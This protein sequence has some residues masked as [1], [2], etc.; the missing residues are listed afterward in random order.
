MNTF[1]AYD[2]HGHFIRQAYYP[3]DVA[4]LQE[5]NDTAWDA[6]R[7]ALHDGDLLKSELERVKAELAKLRCELIDKHSEI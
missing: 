4:E 7:T 3:E 6:Y 1:D 5:D 2:A